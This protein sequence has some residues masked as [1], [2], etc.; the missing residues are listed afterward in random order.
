[1][2]DAGSARRVLSAQRTAA[3]SHFKTGLELHPASGPA[4][5]GESRSRAYL[6]ASQSSFHSLLPRPARMPLRIGC[7]RAGWG[8]LGLL[9]VMG[10][11]SPSS[12]ATGEIFGPRRGN[13]RPEQPRQTSRR[14]GCLLTTG[15]VEIDGLVDALV[16]LVRRSI[17]TSVA[18]F[19][20]ICE[21]HFRMT[22]QIYFRII[23][24]I[25]SFG[26]GAT[27]T[28]RPISPL[29]FSVTMTAAWRPDVS[30]CSMVPQ[31]A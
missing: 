25:L 27:T 13:A 8:A 30:S 1:M 19:I 20:N 14:P 23:T 16:R 22:N 24:T 18:A 26:V 9:V 17:R 11:V 15:Q 29:R 5:A 6:G 21:P 4:R 3:T 10:R 7:G 2:Q 12:P 31:T 28:D